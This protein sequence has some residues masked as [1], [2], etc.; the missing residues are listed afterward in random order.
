MDGFSFPDEPSGFA[1]LFN[2]HEAPEALEVH[3]D[4]E[5]HEDTEDPESHEDHNVPEVPEHI[6][7]GYSCD[8]YFD[9][10]TKKVVSEF[11]GDVVWSAPL[12]TVI[13]FQSGYDSPCDF[14]GYSILV[15]LNEDG[16]VCE[17]MFR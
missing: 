7:V 17:M 8:V 13:Y 4:T 14:A 1:G 16:E 11:E 6:F 3:E 9:L 10:P 15:R 12:A 5:A 2:P